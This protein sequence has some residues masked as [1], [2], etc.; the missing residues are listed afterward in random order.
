MKRRHCLDSNHLR[1]FAL[2]TLDTLLG[3][4][5]EL[6]PLLREKLQVA[7]PELEAALERLTQRELTELMQAVANWADQGRMSGPMT[8]AELNH[9]LTH[10]PLRP[11]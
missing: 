6:P 2:L 4:G 3:D 10:L 8:H 5:M 1:V 9:F 7:S 11:T